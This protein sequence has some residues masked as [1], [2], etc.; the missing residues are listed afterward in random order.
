M[1]KHLDIK[2]HPVLVEKFNDGELNI[3]INECLRGKV[4]Y[5]IQV[6]LNI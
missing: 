3:K 4:I 2:C 1:S 5:L 6:I